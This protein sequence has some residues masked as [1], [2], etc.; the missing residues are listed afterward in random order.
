MFSMLALRSTAIVGN[1]LDGVGREVELDALGR[2][3]RDVLLDEARLGLGQDA[4]ESPPSSSGRSSTRIGRRPCSSGSRSD[5]FDTW[6]APDAMNRMW[7][8]LHR[9]VL[10]GDRRALDQRQQVALHALAR[11]AAADAALARRDLV[12]L[13]EEDDA[14]VLDRFDAPARIDL[15][16]VEQLVGFLVDQQV[17]GILDRGLARLGRLPPMALPSMSPMFITP[18]MPPG[19]P[20]MSKPACRASGVGHLDLDFLVVELAVAQLLAEQIAA[21]PGEAG[22]RR[23]AP[24]STRSSALRCAL[25]LDVLALPL[26]HA[27]RCRSRRDRG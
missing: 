27:G 2:H 18:T 8:G 20:G 16:L 19:M 5:G 21:S 15:V 3:Q 4:D 11:D 13:V 6:N 10:G 17:V 14:V 12:D 1:G 22:R 23:P 7:S 25:R 9:P 26:A 24:S